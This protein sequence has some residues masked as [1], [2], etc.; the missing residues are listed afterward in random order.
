M[1]QTTGLLAGL[2][3]L[4]IVCGG[5]L[6]VLSFV[7]LRFTGRG[8]LSFI[9]VTLGNRMGGSG[10]QRPA[11]IPR[12]R[13][14]LRAKA[15]SADF[16]AALAAEAQKQTTPMPP[17]DPTALTAPPVQRPSAPATHAPLS[18]NRPRRSDDDEIF[19]GMLDVDGDGDPDF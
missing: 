5:S 19:G 13:V 3:G 2:C 4:G 7:L 9:L 17:A 8:L 12:R 10:E 11:R 6:L 16:D 14:D 15:R 18:A 1:D